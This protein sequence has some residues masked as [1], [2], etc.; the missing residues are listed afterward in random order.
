MDIIEFRAYHNH[1]RKA[2]Y[3]HFTEEDANVQGV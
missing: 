2:S 3:L 1:L